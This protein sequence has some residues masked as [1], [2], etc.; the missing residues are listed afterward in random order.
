[1]PPS[2][3]GSFFFLAL[4][5]SGKYEHATEPL[6]GERM[7][8][9]SILPILFFFFLPRVNKLVFIIPET[10]E[11]DRS[12]FSFSREMHCFRESVLC[13]TGFAH[14][15]DLVIVLNCISPSSRAQRVADVNGL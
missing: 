2:Y 12:G 4:H 10:R 1:M 3:A 8:G 13:S 7:T 14:L 9:K 15:D 11:N 5:S 6:A